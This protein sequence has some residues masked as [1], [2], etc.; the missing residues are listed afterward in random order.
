MF[1]FTLKCLWYILPAYLA[2]TAPVFAA[3]I[4][5]ERLSTPV[6]LGKTIKG[7]PLFGNNKTYRGI[8]SGTVFGTIIAFLQQKVYSLDIIKFIS[9]IDYNQSN[10][11]LFGFLMGFGALSGDLIKSFFKRR[12]GIKS[13]NSWIFFDQTDFIF[14]G[15]LFS[16]IIYVPEFKYIA[17]IL[18]ITPFL[19][20]A[21]DQIGYY[22]GICKKL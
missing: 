9:L 13:G 2:N 19:K 12:L 1:L 11:F 8:I 5:G 10:I 22:M 21:I 14:G 20:I 17:G 15:L 4:F 16:S 6:D 18:L 7:N 3:K